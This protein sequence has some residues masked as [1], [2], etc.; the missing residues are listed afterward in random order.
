MEE[1]EI[2]NQWVVNSLDRFLIS[3]D[4]YSIWFVTFYDITTILGLKGFNCSVYKWFPTRY[5]SE[6]LKPD[7]ICNQMKTETLQ[8]QP[9]VFL[10]HVILI[11]FQAYERVRWT[12]VLTVQV[13]YHFCS[14]QWIISQSKRQKN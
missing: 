8:H 3:T 6:F 11:H 14:A 2:L 1:T 10:L 9:S 4:Q 5:A 12:G 7:I 13:I